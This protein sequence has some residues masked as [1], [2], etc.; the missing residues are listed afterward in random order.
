MLACFCNPM[1]GNITDRFAQILLKNDTKNKNKKD[2][3]DEIKKVERQ[4]RVIEV[5]RTLE[6]A[7]IPYKIMFKVA[8]QTVV[9]AQCEP[10][11]L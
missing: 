5:C 11:A 2:F 10:K 3:Q 1:G 8:G 4:L 9:V 6:N 7:P